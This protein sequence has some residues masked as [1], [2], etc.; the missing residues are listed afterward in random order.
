MTLLNWNV[1]DG[2]ITASCA[3][4]GM[5]LY[6][7]AKRTD[8]VLQ[9]EQEKAAYVFGFA[10]DYVTMSDITGGLLHLPTTT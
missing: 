8:R 3:R 4:R 5:L 10:N 7:K 6:L 1:S 2:K 9:Q